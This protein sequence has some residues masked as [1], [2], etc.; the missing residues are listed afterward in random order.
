MDKKKFRFLVARNRMLYGRAEADWDTED[1]ARFA[2]EYLRSKGYN[3]VNVD[4][5]DDYPE[6]NPDDDAAL[7]EEV[8]EAYRKTRRGDNPTEKY[9]R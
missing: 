2:N 1:Y 5:V 6:G 9:A 7:R 4:I 8:E 3:D